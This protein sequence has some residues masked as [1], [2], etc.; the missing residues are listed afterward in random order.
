MRRLVASALARAAAILAIAGC[1]FGPVAARAATLYAMSAESEACGST[2]SDAVSAVDGKLWDIYTENA[3]NPLPTVDCSNGVSAGGAKHIKWVNGA[4]QHDNLIE[5]LGLGTTSMTAGSTWYMAALARVDKSTATDVY[6]TLNSFDKF[7]EFRGT[8]LRWGIGA[9]YAN[10]NYSA[11]VAGKFVWD[12]W[13]AASA[14]TQCETSGGGPDHKA[15]NVSP[16]TAA[17]PLYADYG[18]WYA[19]VIGITMQSSATGLVEMWVNGTKTHAITQ[20]TMN[21]GA[22][23][24]SMMAMGTISQPG[25]DAPA[26]TRRIDGWVLTDSLAAVSAYM[27]DPAGGG[28]PAVLGG[29]AGQATPGGDAKIR[30]P[31]PTL[32]R[33][34]K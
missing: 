33:V 30:L 6:Q 16:Y 21:A 2:V 22:T 14:V 28:S 1:A 31:A 32:N 3:V 25:Y 29:S 20:A 34:P 18:R 10:G 12:V 8:G 5:V 4:A 13:C 11:Y 19:L 7:L 23:I 24:T 26:H 15:P 17:A 27:S 9:G